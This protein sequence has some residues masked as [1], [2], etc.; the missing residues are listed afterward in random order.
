MSTLTSDYL[1]LLNVLGLKA[2]CTS[3]RDFIHN[4]NISNRQKNLQL[5][6]TKLMKVIK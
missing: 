6:I 4:F 3:N 2:I 1:H 5:L